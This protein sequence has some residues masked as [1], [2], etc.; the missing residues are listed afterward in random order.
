MPQRDGPPKSRS[1]L[2]AILARGPEVLDH[3]SPTLKEFHAVLAHSFRRGELDPLSRMEEEVASNMVRAPA[4]CYFGLV[5]RDPDSNDRIVSGMYGSVKDGLLALRY[6]VTDPAY[7]GSGLSQEADELFFT[8][9]RKRA[10]L[11]GREIWV[12]LGECVESSEAYFNRSWGLRRLYLPGPP[13]CYREMYY[14]LPHLGEWTAQG[15]PKAPEPRPTREHLQLALRPPRDAISS[16]LLREVLTALWGEWYVR[17]EQEFDS[18]RAWQDHHDQVMRRT[19]EEKVLAPLPRD[20]ELVLL[21]RE[22]REKLKREGACFVDLD[23][24]A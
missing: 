19:L 11:Q 22:E 6:K 17:P 13:D 9:A 7:R 21:S 24:N 15:R 16:T 8:E 18:A 10:A 4:C 14:E 1:S 5:L 23:L 3:P 20:A 2:E 12:C